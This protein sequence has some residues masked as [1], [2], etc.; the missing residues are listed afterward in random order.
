MRPS[1]KAILVALGIVG[2]AVSIASAQS[3]GLRRFV[4]NLGTA[5][6]WSQLTQKQFIGDYNGIASSGNVTVSVYMG[7]P[8][9]V[10][11]DGS[12]EEGEDGLDENCPV[13]LNDTNEAIFS[14]R[15][16]Y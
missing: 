1:S 16:S 13:P 9:N 11:A 15:I 12:E 10:I 6:R 8:I 7:T 4:V 3:I 5:V 14:R 2:S